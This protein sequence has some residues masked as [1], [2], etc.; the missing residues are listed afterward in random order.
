L[1]PPEGAEQQFTGPA[2]IG[3]LMMMSLPPR[4]MNTSSRAVTAKYA[5]KPFQ[6]QARFTFLDVDDV[7]VNSHVVSGTP[8]PGFVLL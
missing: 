1:N 5:W 4:R 7:V 3:V 8:P 2:L 6:F